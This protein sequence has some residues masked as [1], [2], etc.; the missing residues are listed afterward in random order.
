MILKVTRTLFTVINT[1]S[2]NICKKYH[3]PA[4]KVGRLK[5]KE[6]INWVRQNFA[7]IYVYICYKL[8]NSLDYYLL[9]YVII[10]FFK[11]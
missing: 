9:N 2:C 4:T 1:N 10:E 3:P 5:K 11:F 7:I 8:L 6:K